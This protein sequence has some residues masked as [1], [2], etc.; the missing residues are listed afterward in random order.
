MY[1]CCFELDE[2][3]G[4]VHQ[5]TLHT[6]SCLEIIDWMGAKGCET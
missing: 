2:H 1:L 6:G 4:R 5:S 3:E